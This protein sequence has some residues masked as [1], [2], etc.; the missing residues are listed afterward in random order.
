MKLN[1]TKDSSVTTNYE[2]GE[3]YNPE[4]PELQLYKLT[5]NNLLED[6]YYRE[7]EEALAELIQAAQH[8]D[9]EFTVKLAAY[10][11]EE[12]YL[13]DVPIVLLV[14]ASRQAGAK[15]YVRRY[16]SSVIQRADEP[17]KALAAH[18]KMFGPPT[19]KERAREWLESGA[20]QQDIRTTERNAR[21]REAIDNG[22]IKEVAKEEGVYDSIKQLGVCPSKPLKSV[23]EDALH[24]FDEYQVAKYDRDNREYNMK[25]VLN[26]VRPN[27]R[28]DTRA[29]IFEKVALSERDESVD[30]LE[31]P[32]T[33]ETVISD[34]GNTES[35]WREVLPRMGLFAKVRN[36][37]N[38][39][40][41]G[42]SADDIFSDEDIEY[43]ERAKLYPFRF[44]QA[45][46]AT[47]TAAAADSEIKTW[48]ERFIR[49]TAGNA[50]LPR[51]YI[52]VDLSGSMD[53]PL[54]ENSSMTY[55]EIAAFFGA[56][57]SQADSEVVAFGSEAQ[58]VSLYGE[59]SP[60][61]DTRQIMRTPVGGSTNGWKAI[62]QMEGEYDRIIMLTD[63]QIWDSTGGFGNRS[64]NSVKSSYDDLDTE[65]PLYMVDLSSYGDLVTPENYK[66][67]YNISGWNSKLID[68]IQ[69][70]EESNPLEEIWTFEPV[71]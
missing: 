59:S 67:V 43:A 32:T 7:D 15:E 16:G 14:W 9:P 31:T 11:R 69:L 36:V 38:M 65:I 53:T 6:T 46:L 71:N 51:S 52:C 10:A 28:D 44:Y 33:W 30:P 2:G 3:A 50:H 63:M 35:A 49:V 41:A 19:F 27:P 58:T 17:M 21:L 57:M 1:D 66:N 64:K 25:D 42:L 55:K 40:E 4:S 18:E 39:L 61:D 47:Q 12:L 34:K 54:S 56:V 37:R 48:M 62:D 20:F 23:I 29:E 45:Y 26:L 68:F 13:R 22:D 5:V 70:S 60:L 8:C 24:N